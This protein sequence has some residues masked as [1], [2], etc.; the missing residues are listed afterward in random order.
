MVDLPGRLM[1][2]GPWPKAYVIEVLIASTA[3]VRF[4]ELYKARPYGSRSG[5]EKIPD[6]NS[7][8]PELSVG[9]MLK[10]VLPGSV[11][12]SFETLKETQNLSSNGF[13]MT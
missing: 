10:V 8:I 9:L 7:I 6:R 5:E 11:V 2:L 3:C 4:D 13:A 12:V 1:L